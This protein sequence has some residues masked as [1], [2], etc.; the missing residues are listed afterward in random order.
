MSF[1][2]STLHIAVPETQL[3]LSY[4]AD[5]SQFLW[6]KLFPIKIVDKPYNL[7]R[8]FNKG[9]MLRR[10]DMRV[11]N[12]GVR[13]QFKMDTNLTYQ[14]TDFMLEALADERDRQV[15]DDIIQYDNELIQHLTLAYQI[16]MEFMTVYQVL[17]N[18]ANYGG[19]TEDLSANGGVRQYDANA[20]S[21]SDPMS[22]FR[23][24]I[25]KSRHKLG[26]R[27]F[28]QVVMSEFTWNKI[29]ENTHVQALGRMANFDKPYMWIAAFEAAVGLPPGAIT[30]TSAV[31]NDS[32]E[33]QTDVYKTFIGPDIIFLYVEPANTRFYGAGLSYMFPGG[34]PGAGLDNIKAPFSML[35]L[36]DNGLETVFG[37]TKM[38]LAG[39][40]D[41][42]VMNSEAMY[43]LQ[44]AINPNDT[45]YGDLLKAPTT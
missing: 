26:G 11:G 31:Y 4:T 17:R 1:A 27:A 8:Q 39:G 44:N 33:D 21:D 9:N 2:R 35:M 28:N 41:Q 20:S 23:N 38:R 43:L 40:I 22:D 12:N 30:L 19:N 29:Q 37:G 15:A 18:S 45:A 14:T 13:V 16:N 34:V 42:K 6:D 24:I 32:L 5:F 7:I 10:R 25:T 3:A 36:P